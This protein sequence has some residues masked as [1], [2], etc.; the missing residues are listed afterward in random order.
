MRRTRHWS[1][2]YKFELGLQT[3]MSALRETNDLQSHNFCPSPSRH[4]SLMTAPLVTAL[5]YN[6]IVCDHLAGACLCALKE[7]TMP[8]FVF[9]PSLILPGGRRKDG[10]RRK[11]TQ[12][13]HALTYCLPLLGRHLTLRTL[14][15]TPQCRCAEAVGF[16]CFIRRPFR[17]QLAHPQLPSSL[18]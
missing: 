7:Q 10:R 8:G 15:I 5:R 9:T 17:L 14:R 2:W 12:S 13:V 3:V 4:H 18:P 16:P 6:G 11:T 1:G